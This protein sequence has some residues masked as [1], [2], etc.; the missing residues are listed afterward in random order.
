MH[1]R[2]RVSY[3]PRTGDA[4]DDY[5]IV[6]LHPATNRVGGIDYIVTY[7]GFFADGQHSPL[8]HMRY[9]DYRDVDGLLVAGRLETYPVDPET[10]ERGDKTTD[11]T[12]TNVRFGE[13]IPAARFRPPRGAHVIDE[14]EAPAR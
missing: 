4:P 8:K 14:V 11:T 13:A 10:G 9:L 3:E 12:I 2:L 5:Y 6:Y 1:D 7:P